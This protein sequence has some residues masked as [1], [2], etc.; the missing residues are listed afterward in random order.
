MSLLSK[1][2]NGNN[3]FHLAAMHFYMNL[4]RYMLKKFKKSN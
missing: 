1:D 2:K 4:I 3:C